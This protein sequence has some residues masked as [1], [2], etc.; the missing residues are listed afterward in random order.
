MSEESGGK[1]VQC[2]RSYGK[3]WFQKGGCGQQCHVR[4][5]AK[6]IYQ[7]WYCKDQFGWWGQKPYWVNWQ[8]EGYGRQI[9]SAEHTL[10]KWG[11]KENGR[12]KL[13]GMWGWGSLPYVSDGRNLCMITNEKSSLGKGK[14]EKR[15]HW[16]RWEKNQ[17][18]LWMGLVLNISSL[19]HK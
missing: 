6:S 15:H 17:E 10:K 2:Q 5:I 7:Q 18:H 11:F 4:E 1:R 9:T 14:G 16:W 12:K 3:S 13:D 19:P 8:S